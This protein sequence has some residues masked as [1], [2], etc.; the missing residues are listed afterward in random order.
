M[1]AYHSIAAVED[2]L[3]ER[4]AADPR[5]ADWRAEI[6][7]LPVLSGKEAEARLFGRFPAVGTYAPKGEYAPGQ[8]AAPVVET[9]PIYLICAGSNLRSPDSPRRGG[10]DTAGAH[11]VVEACRRVVEAWPREG[12]LQSIRPARWW[13]AWGNKQLAVCVLEVEVKLARSLTPAPEE[14]EAYGSDYPE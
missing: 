10:P 5:L 14:T 2:E 8:G 7:A 4:L 9:A 11:Q 1:S 6:T 3:L 13:L 12:N